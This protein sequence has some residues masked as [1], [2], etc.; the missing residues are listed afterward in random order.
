M[1]FE[2]LEGIFGLLDRQLDV[3]YVTTLV[4]D[5]EAARLTMRTLAWRLHANRKKTGRTRRQGEQEARG[6]FG[7]VLSACEIVVTQSGRPEGRSLLAE[8]TFRRAVS[9]HLTRSKNPQPCF[10]LPSN[11]VALF[12]VSPVLAPRRE[13]GWP[14]Y[15]CF[16]LMLAA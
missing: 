11:Q 4:P 2:S 5:R 8:G 16:G 7:H 10:P 1:R 6:T 15:I 12:G 3:V 9:S 14:H 13:V